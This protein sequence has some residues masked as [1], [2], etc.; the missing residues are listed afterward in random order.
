MT[1]DQDLARCKGYRVETHDG[2]IG[3]IAAILPRAGR[4]KRGVLLVQSG[5]LSCRLSAIPFDEVETVDPDERR[6]LLREMP[7]TIQK[8]TPS[9]ARDRIVRRA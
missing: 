7:Q 4:Q 8:G 2:R 5:L 9:G 3:N 6:V 1:K